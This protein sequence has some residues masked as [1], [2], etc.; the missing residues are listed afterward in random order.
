MPRKLQQHTKSRLNLL[1]MQYHRFS[2]LLIPFLLVFVASRFDKLQNFSAR[3]LLFQKVKHN[4]YHVIKYNS[5]F[6]IS[7]MWWQFEFKKV[8]NLQI[9][10]VGFIVVSIT[11]PC[12][13]AFSKMHQTSAFKNQNYHSL[14]F[15]P[16]RLQEIIF[17][18]LR[19]HKK[20]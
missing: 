14:I 11:H 12:S 18:M 17:L 1:F 3:L 16:F 6:T 5:K 2:S 4:T 7:K 19:N 20:F 15:N 13:R 8:P 10:G 9:L